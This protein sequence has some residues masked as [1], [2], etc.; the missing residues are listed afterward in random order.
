M[1][2]SNHAG[3]RQ[4]QEKKA[5]A[6]LH[7]RN[8]QQVIPELGRQFMLASDREKCITGAIFEDGTMDGVFSMNRGLISNTI[9][10]V[11][12]EIY[13]ERMLDEVGRPVFQLYGEDMKGLNSFD[14]PGTVRK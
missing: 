12:H 14:P 1:L 2:Y 6:I 5:G 10:L 4:L 9:D 7:G 13:V 8:K 3:L 11:N